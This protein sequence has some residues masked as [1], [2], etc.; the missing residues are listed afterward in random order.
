MLDLVSNLPQ[1]YNAVVFGRTDKMDLAIG[2]TVGTSTQLALLVAH[3]L[4]FLGAVTGQD[5]QKPNNRTT[6]G[7]VAGKPGAPTIAPLPRSR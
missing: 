4:V 6:R 5:G 7:K 1:L 2:V 3:P